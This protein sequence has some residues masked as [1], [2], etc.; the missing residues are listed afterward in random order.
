[1][2]FDYANARLRARKS[3]LLSRDKLVG[4]ARLDNLPS[5]L[6]ALA[7]TPYRRAVDAALTH[8]IELE[9]LFWALHADL[10][11]NLGEMRDF[12]NAGT[13]QWIDLLL[14]TYDVYNLKTILRG[15]SQDLPGEEIKRALLP[16]GALTPGMLEE[17][18]K[19]PSPRAAVD[20][21]AS[22]GS[23]FAHPLLFMRA[24]RPGAPVF[25]MELGLERWHDRQMRQ[26]LKGAPEQ[27][28]GLLAA[29]DIEADLTNILTA[30]RFA[31]SP[32]ERPKLLEQLGFE[33][34]ESLFIGPGKIDLS[35]LA[36]AADQASVEQAV[37]VMARPPYAVPLEEGLEVYSQNRRLSA[38]EDRLWQ[39][40]LSWRARQILKD[41]LGI[42]VP[43]G[44]LTLKVN[45]VRNLRWIG[46]GI[47]LGV[48]AKEIREGLVFV[49]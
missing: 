17:L 2:S 45:E 13:R 43:M 15:L 9:A 5:L 18:M 33:E 30:L 40:Q 42:G 27:A 26:R 20:R 32:Q 24:E 19:A 11:D 25:E 1:M 41:P 38:I 36:Q 48:A 16:I 8:A 14:R 37:E 6:N 47:D 44:Y 34:V 31:H 49:R 3:R 28:R 46:L 23:P 10:V 21:L 39:H 12:F 35:R 22:L 4:F 7:D 29:Q